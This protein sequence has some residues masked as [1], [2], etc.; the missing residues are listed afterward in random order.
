MRVLVIVSLL[1][2]AACASPELVR[3]REAC[4]AGNTQA[5]ATAEELRLQRA[6]AASQALSQSG[7]AMQRMAQPVRRPGPV[8]CQKLGQTVSCVQH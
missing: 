2:L 5:C 1:G 7:A 6:I 4:A 8:I 3:L